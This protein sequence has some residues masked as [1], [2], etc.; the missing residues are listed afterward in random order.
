[1]GTCCCIF[2]AQRTAPSMLS[3]TI[4]QRIAAG[5]DNPATVL[6]Y[7]GIYQLSAQSPQSLEGSSVIQSDQA[8]VANHVGIDHGD[9]LPPIWRLPIQG[10]MRCSPT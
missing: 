4:E 8:A 6:L 1:M 7:R 2:T 10:L 9:Q 3:N 5:L